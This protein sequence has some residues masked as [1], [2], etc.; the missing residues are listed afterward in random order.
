MPTGA[1]QLLLHWAYG[2]LHLPINSN[3]SRL[4]AHR[5]S[6]KDWASRLRPETAEVRENLT[7]VRIGSEREAHERGDDGRARGLSIV[8]SRSKLLVSFMP[9][10]SN[11]S[12]E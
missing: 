6:L 10:Y 11:T 12:R 1:I 3:L 4:D 9:D 2:K 8:H 7:N 5:G